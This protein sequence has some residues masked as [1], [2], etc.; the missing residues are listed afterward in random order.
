[1]ALFL[2]I[3]EGPTAV[4]AQPLIVTGDQGLIELVRQGLM[5]RLE[6]GVSVISKSQNREGGE[7]K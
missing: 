6:G 3:L 1:M 4:D 7:T 2:I 5:Y